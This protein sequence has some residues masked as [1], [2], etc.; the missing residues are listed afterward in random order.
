MGDPFRIA[1]IV[2]KNHS[3]GEWF[4]VTKRPAPFGAGSE[5]YGA[6]VGLQVYLA[7]LLDRTGHQKIR[8]PL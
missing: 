5:R 6:C 3:L 4:L 2:T 8:D 7:I 1:F